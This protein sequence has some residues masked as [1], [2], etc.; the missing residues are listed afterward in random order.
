[1]MCRVRL[2]SIP[3]R[4]AERATAST[5]GPL[6]MGAFSE[7]ELRA[8]EIGWKGRAD[9]LVLSS[10]ACEI[11]DFKTGAYDEGHKFQI[12][13]YALLWNRDGELNPGRR[14]ADRLLLVYSGEEIEVEAPT[15]SELAKFEALLLTRRDAAHEAV[16]AHPPEARPSRQICCNC[17]VRHL[18]DEYWTTK[19]QRQVVREG[20]DRR[21]GDVEVTVTGRHG[22]SSWD[23]RIELLREAPAGMLAVIRSSGELNLRPGD[24][25]RILD[26][27]LTMDDEDPT[28]PVLITLCVMSEAYLIP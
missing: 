20:D 9:L 21:F 18:C 22:P 14:R 24:R 5:R 15:E 8:K 17:A 16:S 4:H 10:D 2:A 1:M 19:T 27:A 25:L 23:G 6:T 11:M 3:A 13:V 12:Q 28:Q 26:A 7:I